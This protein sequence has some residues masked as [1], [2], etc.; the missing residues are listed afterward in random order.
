[1]THPWGKNRYPFLGDSEIESGVI[2]S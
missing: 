1:M 2:R